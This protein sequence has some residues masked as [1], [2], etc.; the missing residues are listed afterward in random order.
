MHKNIESSENNFGY[1]SEFSTPALPSRKYSSSLEQNHESR[2]LFFNNRKIIEDSNAKTIP[3]NERL[4]NFSSLNE[5]WNNETKTL[6]LL[7][8][9][10]NKTQESNENPLKNEEILQKESL[11]LKKNSETTENNDKKATNLNQ[12]NLLAKEP[13]LYQIPEENHNFPDIEKSGMLQLKNPEEATNNDFPDEI[14]KLQEEIKKK[15]EEISKYKEYL[16]S[17]N[18]QY[19][20]ITHKDEIY[21]RIS[22]LQFDKQRIID[23]RRENSKSLDLQIFQKTKTKEHEQEIK[24]KEQNQRLEMLRLM[25]ESEI[26]EREDRYIKAKEYK[27]QLD[28][29]ANVKNNL[30]QQLSQPRN[31]FYQSCA[32]KSELFKYRDPN[33]FTNTPNELVFFPNPSKFTK[34]SPKTMCYNP[35]TGDLKDTSPYLLGVHPSLSSVPKL[36]NSITPNQSIISYENADE[37]KKGSENMNKLIETKKTQEFDPKEQKKKDDHPT[38]KNLSGYGALI[39]KN[40]RGGMQ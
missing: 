29:Q 22:K 16:N 34:K 6:N 26:R 1:K 5:N 33:P 27:E 12:N 13:K 38:D 8:I 9:K 3:N 21:Q 35:I 28:F 17:R 15:E 20:S 32:N 30:K 11:E 23:Q 39:L 19:K 24:G 4:Q 7:D 2:G 14:D 36:N 40:Q 25:R 10:N 18:L 31:I 37:R